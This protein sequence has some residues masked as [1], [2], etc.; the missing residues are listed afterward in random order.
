ML[1]QHGRSERAVGAAFVSP[2]LQRGETKLLNRAKESRRD[3]ANSPANG[4]HDE[5]N[6]AKMVLNGKK[7]PN[8]IAK[9]GPK[10]VA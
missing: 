9:T 2:A 4:S 3:D 1:R 5:I 8:S 6:G 7:S 10:L